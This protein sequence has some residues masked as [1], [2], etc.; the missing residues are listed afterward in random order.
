MRRFFPLL[1]VLT[2]FLVGIGSGALL[3]EDKKAHADEKG[4]VTKDKDHGAKDHDHGGGEHKKFS[5]LD[6]LRFDTGLWSL[7][8]FVFL[9]IVLRKA[10]WGPILEGLQ[11]REQTIVSSLEEAKKTRVE[12]EQMRAQFKTELDA[13]YAKIPAMMEEARRDAEAM[14]EQMKNDANAAIQADRQRLMREIGTAKDQ[15]IH[16]LWNQA[17][18]LATLISAKAIGR[19]LTEDDHRRLLQEALQE[20]G[21]ASQRN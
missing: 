13:A 3:A 19:S 6:V 5:P 2:L 9:L 4:H 21:S 20:L 12:M 14:R 15:A 16:E 11:K 1:C 7:V 18:Q 8:V 17:A 10:A